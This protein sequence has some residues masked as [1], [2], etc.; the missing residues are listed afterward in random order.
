MNTINNSPYPTGLIYR[1]PNPHVYSKHA[2][3][4]SIAV[5]PNGDLLASFAIGEAFEAANL[6]TYISRS[7]DNG[8]TWSDPVPFFYEGELGE[9]SNCARIAAT[10]N[11]EVVAIVVRSHRGPYTGQGFANP[12][13]TGFVPTDVFLVRSKDDGRSWQTPE[14]I[15]PPLVGPSFELCS[16]IIPLSDGRWI[17]PTTTWRGWDGYCP[18]GMKMVV[19]VS[20]DQGKTWP[21]YME[22]MDGTVDQ[23]V[24]WE[25]KILELKS[26]RLISVAWAYNERTRKDKE[27]HYTISDDGGRTWSVPTASGIL[28]QTMAIAEL[29]DSRLLAVYRR[30]DKPGLWCSIVKLAGQEWINERS[31]ALWGHS[32]NPTSSQSMNM[33][34]NFNGLKFGAPT[35]VHLPDGAIYIAFWCYEGLVAN[36]RWFRLNDIS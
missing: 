34:R 24:Y 27:N 18:N 36:I 15:P 23:T 9:Y 14:N 2:Y 8:E 25:S 10:P 29:S 1:N 7:V 12:E 11:G 16:P 17:W 22:V 5:M 30:M 6:N 26:G 13:N 28:G 31:F 19:F 3:F 4:P 32:E 20:T 35:V 21:G 33:V